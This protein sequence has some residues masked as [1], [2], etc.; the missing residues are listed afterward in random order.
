MQLFGYAGIPDL[1][2]PNLR[3][4]K[5]SEATVTATPPELRRIAAFLEHCAREMKDMGEI[6]DH[7][8]LGDWDKHFSDMPQ[9]IVATTRWD[10]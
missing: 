5:L 9:F 1:D 3:P 8:H 4:L 6:Y 2:D 7:I 10:E